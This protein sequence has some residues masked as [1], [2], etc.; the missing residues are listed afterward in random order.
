[1]KGLFNGLSIPLTG[2]RF[3]RQHPGLWR[4]GWAPIFINTV[5]SVVV[6]LAGLWLRSW[7]FSWIVPDT[8]SS[9]WGQALL[10]LGYVVSFVLLLGMVVATSI[11]LSLVLCA[12]F[13]GRLSYAVERRMGTPTDELTEL[14]MV[15]EGLEAVRAL[16]EI[17]WIN[18]LLLA[19]GFVPVA[20]PVLAGGLGWYWNSY[21]L[22]A[23]FFD[24]PLAL[25][26][27]R[28]K[29]RRRFTR[30][31]RMPVVG[32]G[33]W[34]FFLNMVPVLGALVLNTA[35]VGVT[36]RRAEYPEPKN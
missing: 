20:G 14:S 4:Y 3:M 25:R 16:I 33:T 10:W 11:T 12:Y 34:I 36:V 28:R 32:L 29:R 15:V 5:V 31:Y 23:E 13:Y 27:W 26:G 7:V 35:V 1:M 18:L 21:I 2:W 9:W 8:I 30:H 6:L 17:V 24:Y 19:L 22:G